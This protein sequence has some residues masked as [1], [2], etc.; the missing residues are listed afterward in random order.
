M[1]RRIVKPAC[2]IGVAAFVL[3]AGVLITLAVPIETWR[4]GDQRL[5][6]LAFAPVLAAPD[7]PRRLWIDTD[8]ACG[9]SRRPDP[10]DCF[11]IALLAH[12]S[13]FQIVGI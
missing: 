4:T 11:A 3:I 2:A 12:A 10:D 8:A 7:A 13:D 1:P 9:N 5:S 6:P